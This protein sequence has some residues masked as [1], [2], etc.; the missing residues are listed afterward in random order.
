MS[1]AEIFEFHVTMTVV[2]DRTSDRERDVS[3]ARAQLTDDLENV[4]ASIWI[5]D[6]VHD[7]PEGFTFTAK[8]QVEGDDREQA[9]NK[10]LDG[11]DEVGAEVHISED[12]A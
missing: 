4:S 12:A 6:E 8:M 11:F 5:D 9:K 10:A 3:E 1:D 2:T 7:H